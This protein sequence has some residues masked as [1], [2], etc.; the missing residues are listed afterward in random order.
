[1]WLATNRHP[2]TQKSDRSPPDR[3]RGPGNLAGRFWSRFRLQ[4]FVCSMP[5]CRSRR[6]L[7]RAWSAPLCRPCNSSRPWQWNRR[8][9]RSRKPRSNQPHPRAVASPRARLNLCIPWPCKLRPASAALR[10]AA[11]ADRNPRRCYQWFPKMCWS[12]VF[13]L[14]QF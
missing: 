12:P 9:C 11:T 7:W 1:M 6:W 14:K 3:L 4:S 10:P 8:S 2:H 5:S 13:G